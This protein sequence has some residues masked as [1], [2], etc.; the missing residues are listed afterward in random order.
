[1]TNSQIDLFSLFNSVTKSLKENQTELNKADEYN[2][3]HGDNMVEI[4][5][6]ITQAMK[7]KKNAAPADQLE[8]ASQLLR[9]K[10][11]S[12]SAQ[13]YANGL[14]QAAKNFGAGDLD[15]GKI[16]Q[17]LQTIMGGVSAVQ[18][19]SGK[20]TSSSGDMLGSLLSGLSGGTSSSGQEKGFDLSDLL[21]AGMSYMQAKQSGKDDM[22]ALV[23]ALVGSTEMGK[24]PY[25]SKS[26][27]IV[28]STILQALGSMLNK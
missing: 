26:S 13:V 8:Y 19:A 24:S 16:L 11:K 14:N 20:Q 18:S 7:A 6:V 22:S 4:F 2:H 28:A 9:Q 1:M 27:E 23:G 21:G 25:R 15:V 3:D 10:S 17:L 5:D 12:G